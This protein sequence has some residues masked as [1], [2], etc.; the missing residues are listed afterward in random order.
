M[1]S[2]VEAYSCTAES[3]VSVDMNP[4]VT[5]LGKKNLRSAGRSVLPRAA[6][7]SLS[8]MH[9]GTTY[10][11]GWSRRVDMSPGDWMPPRRARRW[12][13]NVTTDLNYVTLR[14]DARRR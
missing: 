11:R 10:A 12:G 6:S 7:V 8:G 2:A 5:L 9:V 14:T 4:S 3:F 13:L 1:Y